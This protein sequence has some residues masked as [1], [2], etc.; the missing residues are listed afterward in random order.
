M[1][2]REGIMPASIRLG[3][4]GGVPIGLH[5]SWFIIAALITFSLANHFR[6]THPDWQ[7]MLIWSTS[8]A[9]AAL[10]FVTLLTH[11]LSHAMV[12][13][14]RGLPVRSITLFALGGIA[15]IERDVNTARTEF[16]V[17][18]VGPITSFT[19]GLICIGWF[20]LIAAQSSYAQVTI[21]EMLRDVR[22]ADVMGDDCAAVDAGTNL[23]SLARPST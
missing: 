16:F 14:A 18:I 22:V 2:A 21:N 7:T 15:Q 5:Y 17:A 1:R 9:T 8:L 3:R 20:L 19:I 23:Q 10:F 12:A 13:K 11:E 4:V 6:V